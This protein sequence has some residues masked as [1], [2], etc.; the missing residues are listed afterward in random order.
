M[1][2]VIILTLVNGERHIHKCVCVCGGGG[3]GGIIG[4]INGNL[5]KCNLNDTKYDT[6]SLQEA[7]CP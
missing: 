6:L 4:N 5:R 7:Q 3:G 2:P 1:S